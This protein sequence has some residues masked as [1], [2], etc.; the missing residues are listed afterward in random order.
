MAPNLWAGISVPSAPRQMKLR[1]LG[2]SIP[3]QMNAALIPL[4]AKICGIWL[5]CP[6]M[7]GM[8][9]ALEGFAPIARA[10]SRP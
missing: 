4:R 1:R 3:R 2:S 5:L 6:N 10:R 7:S 9:P 8:Y